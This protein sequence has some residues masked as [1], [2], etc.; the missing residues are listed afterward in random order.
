MK[1]VTSTDV[2]RLAGVSQSTVSMVLNNKIGPSFSEETKNKV[3]DAARQLG[4]MLPAQSISVPDK[5]IIAVFIPTLSNPY[6]TQLTSCIEKYALSKGYKILL[7]NTSR[8]KEYESYYLDYFSK[9]KVAGIIFTFV[10]SYPQMAEQLALSLPIVLIGEKTVDMTIPSIE[11]NN[12]KAGVIMGEHLLSLG[13]SHFA[14][15]STPLDNLSLARRQRLEGLKIALKE[16]MPQGSLD[17]FISDHIAES[18]AT[19]SPYEYEVGYGLTKKV[20]SSKSSAT[21]LIG[22]NDMTA[23]GIIGCLYDSG[24]HVPDHYSVC[25]FD[26]IFVSSVSIPSITT[27]EHHLPLRGQSA[28]DLILSRQS[29]SQIGRSAPLIAPQVNKIEYDPELLIRRSTGPCR[30]NKV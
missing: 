16:K 12:V 14:F 29:A 10:P 23:I 18:D 15:L 26:N 2:A 8:N 1:K 22:V 27:I 9:T 24:F 7:C 6:Y 25:G 20:L 13:H 17:I 28:V 4:Y 11:L 3:L 5:N 21:A 19:T 30:C